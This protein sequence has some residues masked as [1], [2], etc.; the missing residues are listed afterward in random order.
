MTPE[1]L[2][3]IETLIARNQQ[4]DDKSFILQ[5]KQLIYDSEFFYEKDVK[6]ISELAAECIQQLKADAPQG[7]F[8]K[9]GFVD[10]DKAIGGFL[11]GEFVVIGGR[12]AMGKTS[13][14][15]DLSKNISISTPLLYITLELSD[16]QLTNR[17]IASILSAPLHQI[18]SKTFTPVECDYISSKEKEL[19]SRQLFLL[20]SRSNSI[21]VLKAHCEKQ[22]S[23]RGVKVIVLDYLQLASSYQ[24][25][26][27]RELE[28]SFVCRELKNIAKEHQVCV[29]VSSQ[30]NRNL[31]NRI[32]YEGKCPQLS[33]LRESGAIEQDADKVILLHRPE[34]YHILTDENGNSLEGIAEVFVAKNRNGATNRI[35][36]F[37]N[38]YSSSFRDF[39][40]FK[41]TFGFS[42]ER[43]KDLEENSF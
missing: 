19:A 28:V 35:R 22:I 8:I 37:F 31:E 40:D 30:L 13:F 11:P 26:K 39:T 34:Y 1:L 4:S 21:A 32:G 2:K 43:L 23:E 6:P 24:H 38:S 14:L 42:P 20:D 15:V 17:F 5:L 41:S 10:L 12:P 25:R 7:N 9:T 3:K 33:D 36:L 29:I 18:N 27:Y 16:R